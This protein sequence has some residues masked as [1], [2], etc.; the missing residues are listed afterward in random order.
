MSIK[1]TCA[2]C[3][4]VF[5]L[6][7]GLN[8]PACRMTARIEKVKQTF[9]PIDPLRTALGIERLSDTVSQL[10]KVEAAQWYWHG[11]TDYPGRLCAP[12]K[13]EKTEVPE[14]CKI[15]NDKASQIYELRRIFRL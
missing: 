14:K 9:A 10:D 2:A 1:G 8:C 4:F 5:L 13:I 3:G 11:T 15:P 7:F 6:D 12:N